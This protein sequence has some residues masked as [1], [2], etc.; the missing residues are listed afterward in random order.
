MFDGKMY[1]VLNTYIAP[2]KVDIAIL[3][4]AKPSEGNYT[5]PKIGNPSKNSGKVF[6]IG[7]PSFSVNA[8]EYS[9]EIGRITGFR[10]LITEDGV[11]FKVIDS[12]AFITFG[13][14]GGGLFD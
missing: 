8:R 14:S 1:N 13:S 10:E 4:I 11:S 3:E 6:A 7:Y 12:D 9:K 2:N 5:V